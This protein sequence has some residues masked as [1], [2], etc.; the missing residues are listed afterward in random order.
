MLLNKTSC[1]S[2]FVN[3]AII[4]L[5]G[6]N[7]VFRSFYHNLVTNRLCHMSFAFFEVFLKL[8]AKCYNLIYFIISK[9]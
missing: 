4:N 3:G 6:V 7:F 2:V 1:S 5:R 9:H 8:K